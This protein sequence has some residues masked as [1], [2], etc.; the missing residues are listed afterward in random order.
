MQDKLTAARNAG[1]LKPY[2]LT[3]AQVGDKVDLPF[4]TPCTVLAIHNGVVVL[5]QVEGTEI[6]DYA[7]GIYHK[8]HNLY[9]LP[10]AW[11]KDDPIYIG[12]VLYSTSQNGSWNVVRVDDRG[13]WVQYY[14]GDYE[15]WPISVDK[16]GAMSDDDDWT[17]TPKP[18]TITIN[19][20]DVPAPEVV[21]PAVG[22]RYWWPY[23]FES[24]MVA[25]SSWNNDVFDVRALA[26]G[27]VH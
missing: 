21:P 3:Q 23:L 16:Y 11:L 19:G 26:R 14:H 12:T 27:I 5:G 2:D 18:R 20:I 15:P 1:K 17:L 22:T 4:T 9:H 8:E 7:Q 6:Y 24:R 10:V 25:C 13:V